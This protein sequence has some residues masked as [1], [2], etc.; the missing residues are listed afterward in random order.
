M[1]N[2]PLLLKTLST[3]PLPNLRSS[4]LVSKHLNSL[5]SN[6]SALQYTLLIDELGLVLPELQDEA[7][8]SKEKLR[9]LKEMEARMREMKF[10]GGQGGNRREGLEVDDWMAVIPGA[11]EEAD[12]EIYMLGGYE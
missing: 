9:K 6:S 7:I 11:I 4:R 10:G 8:N 3:L 2:D 1:D 5:I 12:D